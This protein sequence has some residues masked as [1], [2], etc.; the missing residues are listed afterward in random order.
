[1][2]LVLPLTAGPAA[3]HAI[4]AWAAA[5]RVV[6]FVILWAAWG[7]GLVALLAPRPLGLTVVRTVAPAFA[8]VAIAAAIA[9]DAS[10]LSALG[11]VLTTV[12]AAVLVADPAVA[13]A[14]AN[15]V[16]YGEE[17]RFPL[18]TPPALYLGP[19][20]AAR[21]LAVGGIATGPLLLADGDIGWG[22]AALVLGV[23]LAF[24]AARS[25]HTLA[26]R[27]LVIVPAGLVIVDAMTLADPLLVVR[28]Q[29]RGVRALEPTEPVAPGAADLRLG[30]TLGVA[31]VELDGSLDVVRTGRRGRGGD[32]VRSTALV[33]AVA[34]RDDLL[35]RTG[36]RP[37]TR[38]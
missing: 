20:P 14:S 23:P 17:R 13:V 9:D 11:A 38:V 27:W 32:T 26:R 33:V 31:A 16:A 7:A 21:L 3:S 4:D 37:S 5:P 1:V 6:A 35:S 18:R 2:W 15:G 8:V 22:V 34:G 12:A 19:I 24:L 25:L 30:A 10:T 29:L 36:R 28:R